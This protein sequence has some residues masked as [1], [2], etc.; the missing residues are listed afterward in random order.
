M[1]FFTTKVTVRLRTGKTR[2]CVSRAG[3]LAM[4]FKLAKSA[5]QHRR[6]LKGAARLAQVIDG[7][8]FKDGLQQEA[9]RIAA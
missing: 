4:V 2:G 7:V 1:P 6:R 8:Q 3:I 5:E 9:Q